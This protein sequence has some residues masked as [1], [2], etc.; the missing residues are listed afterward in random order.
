MRM[1]ARSRCFGEVNDKGINSE[2][3]A[4]GEMGGG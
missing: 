2:A 3:K 1:A 4:I